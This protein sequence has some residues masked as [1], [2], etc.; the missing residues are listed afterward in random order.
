MSAE[1]RTPKAERLGPKTATAGLANPIYFGHERLEVFQLSLG[2]I[3]DI[4][5]A[6]AVRP[7]A[8]VLCQP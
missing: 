2:L 8:E 1:R 7:S 6:L 5:S 4:D 3:E